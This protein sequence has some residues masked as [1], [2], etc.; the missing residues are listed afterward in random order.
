MEG[1]RDMGPHEGRGCGD[2]GEE[3][4]LLGQ[5][6][7]LDVGGKPREESRKMLRFLARA[8]VY[9]GVVLAE[10][11]VQEGRRLLKGRG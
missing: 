4:S 3:S 5:H 2:R 6:G 1:N 7:Q 8:V 9:K 11:K 10:L